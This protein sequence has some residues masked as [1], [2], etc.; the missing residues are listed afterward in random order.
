MKQNMTEKRW[1]KLENF[2]EREGITGYEI[3][4]PEA[5]RMIITT[6][7]T[8]YTAKEFIKNNHEFGLII[9]KILKPLNEKLRDEL[10]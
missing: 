7:F 4:N 10:V 2:F 3:I 9:I 5:K 8:S 6:S 1:K